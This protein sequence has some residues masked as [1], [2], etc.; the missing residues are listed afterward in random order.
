MH[1]YF[2]QPM[3][4]LFIF[5]CERDFTFDANFESTYTAAKFYIV[6][7]MITNCNFFNEIIA[8]A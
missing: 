5:W 3:S 7:I 4:Y 1:L 8:S 2:L 6:I